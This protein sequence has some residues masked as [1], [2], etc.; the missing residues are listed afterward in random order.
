M[1][2]ARSIKPSFFKNEHLAECEP[3]ARLLFIGLWTLADRDGR[4]ENRPLRIKA[5]LFPYENCDMV[6]L[7][8][9]LSDRGFVRAYEA[10]DKRVLEIPKFREHQRCHPEERSEGL[11]PPPTGEKPGSPAREPGNPTTE[12]GNFPVFPCQD[13]AGG[14]TAVFPGENAKPGNPT[15]EPGSPTTEPGS[16][17]AICASFL[18]PSSS[19][20]FPSTGSAPSSPAPRAGSEPSQ[21]IRWSA[22]A[23]WEGITDGDR[24]EWAAAY[25]AADIAVELARATQWLK[26]NP[27]K[28]KKSNWRKWLTTTWL[29]GCQDR[30]GTHR[31]RGAKPTDR[32]PAADAASDWARGASDPEAARRRREFLDAKARKA[33]AVVAAPD[34]ATEEARAVV[35]AKLR[36]AS[37]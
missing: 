21:A 35:L 30:G 19:F 12:P 11:P 8:K 1:A 18:L 10:G 5:E 26:A 34:D 13:G 14:E 20:P 24:A 28:A 36:E 29:N 3:M 32:R 6:S 27:K 4:L 37:A 22:D 9:Q 2:R 17:P 23:G 15:M 25:P 31:E 33:G 7:L 16:F